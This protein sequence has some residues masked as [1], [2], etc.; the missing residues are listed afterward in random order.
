MNRSVSARRH[1]GRNLDRPDARLRLR[2]AAAG[3]VA[4]MIVGAGSLA[5]A[6]PVSASAGTWGAGQYPYNAG[7]VCTSGTTTSPLATYDF[8]S[9]YSPAA[10]TSVVTSTG[11]TDSAALPYPTSGPQTTV[12][13]APGML[14][15]SS[16]A[17]IG[18]YAE[19]LNMFGTSDAAEVARI[20][21]AKTSARRTTGLCQRV[22]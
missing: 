7:V 3:I 8:G 19:L 22:R 17:D 12:A 5:F 15:F 20:V 11:T 13:V 14:G 21:L 18:T 16:P 2:A 4:A 9:G 10:L 6:Q 1:F